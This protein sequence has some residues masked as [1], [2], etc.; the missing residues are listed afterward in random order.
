MLKQDLFKDLNHKGVWCGKSLTI[1]LDNENISRNCF[2]TVTESSKLHLRCANVTS[3]IGG[4]GRLETCRQNHE[5]AFWMDEYVKRQR[6]VN[7]NVTGN[8]F[9]CLWQKE[10]LLQHAAWQQ[11]V[12]LSLTRLSC[13]RRFTK[14]QTWSVLMKMNPTEKTFQTLKL[15]LERASQN[16]ESPENFQVVQRAKL[17]WSPLT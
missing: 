9:L 7:L 6:H 13:V 1:A 17:K 4:F 14:D 8:M 12:L 15:L 11:F 2:S 5:K 16:P 3:L 10:I